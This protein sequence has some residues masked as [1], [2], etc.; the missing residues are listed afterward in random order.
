MQQLIAGVHRFRDDEFGN[1]RKLFRKLSQEGQNPHTLFITCSDSRVLA[2]LITQSKPGDLFVVKNVGNIV[3]PASAK[4]DTNSTAAAIEFAVKILHV[5]DIVICGH[6]QCGAISALLA[7]TP[8][9]DSTPHLRDWLRLA[10][11][12]LDTLKKEYAHLHKASEQETAAAEENVL[13]GLDNLRGYPCVQERLGDGTL[14]LHGWFFKI[15]T[16]ELFA[17]DPH[18]LQFL[19]LVSDK[20]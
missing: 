13:F 14:Q 6:S 7:K 3:P 9:S 20:E 8:V 2:E 1:Y 16:A 15:A 19:P 10:T 18:T 5:N 17:Y 11:P 4:G 12:V